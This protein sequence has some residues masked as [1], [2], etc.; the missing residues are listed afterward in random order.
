M[1]GPATGKARPSTIVWRTAPADDWSQQ[2]GGNAVATANICNSSRLLGNEKVEC[3]F[4]CAAIIWWKK[5]IVCMS[6]CLTTLIS[7]RP[8]VVFHLYLCLLFVGFSSVSFGGWRHISQRSRVREITLWALNCCGARWRPWSSRCAHDLIKRV[9]LWNATSLRPLA[10]EEWLL[11]PLPCRS[12][13]KACSQL[14]NSTELKFE[15]WST[16]LPV[17][18]LTED[19][20]SLAL[21]YIL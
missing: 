5:I 18:L 3:R 10:T 13:I 4:C 8:N 19:F 16:C 17:A 11:P 12:C 7:Q 14:A 20:I 2:N 1:V 9:W 21:L 15:Y 6:V